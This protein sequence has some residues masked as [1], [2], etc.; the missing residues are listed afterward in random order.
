M[1][2][3]LYLTPIAAALVL[4][5]SGTAKAAEPVFLHNLTIQKLQK[6]FHL[7]IPGHQPKSNDAANSLQFLQEHVDVNSVSHIRMQQ[8]YQNFVVEGG[9][10]IMHSAAPTQSLLASSNSVT[11]TGI[12]FEQLDKDLGIPNA[13]FVKNGAIALHKMKEKY[14]QKSISNEKITPVIYIDDNNTAH[15]AYKIS[16]IVNS[17]LAIPA[18]PTAIVDATT[19]KPYKEW[20]DIKTAH[21]PVK[22]MGYGGNFKSGEIVYGK[23]FP[24]LD[25]SH[26]ELLD[27]CYM[28]NSEVKV[29]DMLHLQLSTNKAMKFPCFQSKKTP[30]NTYWTGYF[31]N[32]FDKKNGAYSPSNDALYVGYVIK[33]LY[34]DWYNTQVLTKEDGSPMKLVMRVHYGVKFENAYWDGDQMTFGD[35]DDMFYPLVSLGI[36]AHEVSHGFT[37]QHSNLEYYGQSGGMNESFS[38][39]AAQAAIYYSTGTNDWLVGAE[40]TKEDSGYEALRYMDSPSKDGASLDSTDGYYNGMDVH[41]SSGV[42]NRLFYLIASSPEWTTRKAFDVMVKANMDYWTPNTTFN[43]GSCGVLRAATDLGYATDGIK[44]ALK[45][46]AVDYSICNQA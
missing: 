37:E 5:V 24:L 27:L 34:E 40:I 31:Q 29:V 20:N 13:N 22:G 14:D 35:G 39:M 1:H 46:V 3:P 28:E 15:W 16:F 19:Y 36:G 2:S 9:Y 18:K 10:A 11:M 4:T 23:N 32:G 25:I 6:E 8:K 33:H 45:I 17:E 12:L 43:E 26:H 42:Y 41:Y 21:K 30:Y 7:S 38:D 44:D